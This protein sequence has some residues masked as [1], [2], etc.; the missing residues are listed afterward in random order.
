MLTS[1]QFEVI[2]QFWKVGYFQVD[3][4]RII[5]STESSRNE[6]ISRLRILGLIKEENFKFRID[7][8]RYL[9]MFQ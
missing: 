7:R 8:E 4:L 3:E 9:E 5:Y 2:K 1:K 6:C